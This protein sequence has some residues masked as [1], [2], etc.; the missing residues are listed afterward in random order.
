V[1]V[2]TPRT[3]REAHTDLFADEWNQQQHFQ[4]NKSLTDVAVQIGLVPCLNWGH[5]CPP[6]T[7]VRT[8]GTLVEAV[9]AAVYIDGGYDE[10][11]KLLG[12]LGFLELDGPPAARALVSPAG[13]AAGS[14]ET[15]ITAK[16]S[17]VHQVLRRID[18]DL[19]TRTF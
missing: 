15:H 17:I 10:A 12:R 19:T 5:T 9:V 18:A 6:T 11:E 13:D 16:T 3:C 8:W 14:A 4:S 1:D 2:T 7:D